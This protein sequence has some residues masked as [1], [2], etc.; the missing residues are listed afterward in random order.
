[1]IETKDGQG[2]E[3]VHVTIFTLIAELEG[4]AWVAC[5]MIFAQFLIN[6]VGPARLTCGAGEAYCRDWQLLLLSLAIG[7]IIFSL[8]ALWCFFRKTA[9]FPQVRTPG[10][11][12]ASLG[13]FA[14]I[15]VAST[16]LAGI[17]Y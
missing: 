3:Q 12:L 6:L 2:S 10:V 15:V 13:A 5:G 9:L 17:F 7:L 8:I 1:M 14:G 4:Y 11:I 16:I